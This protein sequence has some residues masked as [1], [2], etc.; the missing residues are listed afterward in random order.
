[1]TTKNKNDCSLIDTAALGFLRRHEQ[2]HSSNNQVLFS[3]TVNFLRT[4]YNAGQAEA[5]NAAARAYGELRSKGE[6]RYLDVS[7]S[8]GNVA[9]IADPATGIHHALPI[10]QIVARMIDTPSRRRLRLVD[11]Q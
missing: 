1:M 11:H 2:Q 8:S 7:T 9:V 10:A 5:E 3:H 6:R 4:A